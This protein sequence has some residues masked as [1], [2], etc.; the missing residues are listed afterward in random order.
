LLEADGGDGE[1][2]PMT[3]RMLKSWVLQSTRPWRIELPIWPLAPNRAM[4][5]SNM[6]LSMVV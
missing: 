6:V 1:F 2:G 4:F 3:A 5:L